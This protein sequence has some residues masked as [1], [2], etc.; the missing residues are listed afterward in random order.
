MKII[1]TEAWEGA[2]KEKFVVQILKR[3]IGRDC[4]DGLSVLV[5]F[6]RAPHGSRRSVFHRIRSLIHQVSSVSLNEGV[7]EAA[8]LVYAYLDEHNGLSC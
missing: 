3:S 4:K 2:S 8:G 5:L 7:G 1:F 6:S